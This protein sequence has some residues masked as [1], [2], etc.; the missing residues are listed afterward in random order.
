MGS[1]RWRSRLHERGSNFFLFL[2]ER[3][4]QLCLFSGCFEDGYVTRQL[5]GGAY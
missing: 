1:I 3:C 4:G 5:V 2:S